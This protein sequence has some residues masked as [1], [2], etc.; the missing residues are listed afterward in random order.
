[1]QRWPAK[2]SWG[3]PGRESGRPAIPDLR[4]RSATNRSTL[5]AKP[6]AEKPF[7][8]NKPSRKY[9]RFCPAQLPRR[10]GGSFREHRAHAMTPPRMQHA[11]SEASLPRGFRFAATACGLKKTGALDFPILS[12]NVPPSAA[13]VFTQNLVV[14]A[15]L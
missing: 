11:L 14:A 2:K 6:G 3:E 12:T 5:G 7:D 1:M 15:P 10:A 4:D 9:A 8:F 13:G